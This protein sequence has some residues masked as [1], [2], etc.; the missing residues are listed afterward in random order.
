MELGLRHFFGVVRVVGQEQKLL[1]VALLGLECV[2][3]GGEGVVEA[4][5][6]V[7]QALHDLLVGLLD[8]ESLVVL[9]HG[10]VQP[11]LQDPNLPHLRVRLRR[12]QPAT[13]GEFAFLVLECVELCTPLVVR[14][15]EAVELALQRLDL[16][17]DLVELLLGGLWLLLPDLGHFASERVVLLLHLADDLLVLLDAHLGGLVIGFPLAFQKR[18]A[19]PQIVELLLGRHGLRGGNG[20]HRKQFGG[21]PRQAK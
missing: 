18:E 2:L 1:I 17:H 10:L 3:D 11:V 12:D 16:S 14:V 19:A 9:D 6:L 15:L 7:L 4:S 21:L 13:H 20:R 5:S 8:A